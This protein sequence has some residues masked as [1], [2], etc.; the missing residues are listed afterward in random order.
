VKRPRKRKL[1]TIP[2]E[3]VKAAADKVLGK[4]WGRLEQRDRVGRSEVLVFHVAGGWRLK[5]SADSTRDPDLV[6]RV[7]IGELERLA[8]RVRE[9]LDEHVA[10]IDVTAITR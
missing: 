1:P 10:S 9:A 2:L 5:F 8:E 6:R 7:A 3:Q 4:G